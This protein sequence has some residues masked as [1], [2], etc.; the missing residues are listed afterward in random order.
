MGEQ[1]HITKSH[2][3]SLLLYH[4]VCP[5]KYRR[6]VFTR[7]VER[8]LKNVCKGIG[9]RYEIYTIEIGCDEDHVHFL[10]QSVPTYSPTKIIRTIKSITAKKLFKNHPEVKK[11]LWGGK[12]WTSGYY[13]NTVGQYSNL[14]TIKKYVKNQGKRYHKIYRGELKL[15]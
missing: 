2:N 5:A 6:K 11:L 7:A 12:L 4:F 10:L 3:K 8:T 1:R 9:E 13:V 15:F 14:E